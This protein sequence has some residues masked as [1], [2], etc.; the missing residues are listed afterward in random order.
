MPYVCRICGFR[1][2]ARASEGAFESHVGR[3]VAANQ[4]FIDDCRPAGQPFEGDPELA[5]FAREEG[6]VYNRRPGTRRRPH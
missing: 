6:S 3:C 4:D 5:L 1:F 2:P